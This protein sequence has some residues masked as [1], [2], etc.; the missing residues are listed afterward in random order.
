LISTCRTSYKD[1]IWGENFKDYYELDGFDN[2]ETEIA[3]KKYFEEYK[4]K[5]NNPEKVLD[6]FKDPIYLRIFCEIKNKE[7]ENIVEVFIGEESI[8]DIFEDYIDICDREISKKFGLRLASKLIKKGL[9]KI[10]TFLWE[11]NL[12]NI[13]IE[14][15]QRLIGDEVNINWENSRTKALLDENLVLDKDWRSAN[16]G[17]VLFFT[18]DRLAGF[19][20]AKTFMELERKN[21]EKL[22]KS[23]SFANRFDRKDKNFH[24]LFDDILKSLCILTPRYFNKLYIHD[25]TKDQNLFGSSV[26]ALFEINPTLISEASVQFI[27]KIFGLG[28]N[29]KAFLNHSLNTFFHVGHPLN[30]DFLSECMKQM[31]MA[32]RDF[33]WTEFLRESYILNLDDIINKIRDRFKEFRFR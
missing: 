26:N 21:F 19:I 22:I 17:E 8:D 9:N 11:N 32:Q 7:R 4:I 13:P 31:V 3:V 10:G 23:K 33:F 14:D 15:F 12:R 1:V 27:K 30:I 6:Y 20:I 24:P 29:P 18:Y 5:A 16:E 25:L 2:F 28:D